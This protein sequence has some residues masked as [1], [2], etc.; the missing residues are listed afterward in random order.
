MLKNISVLQKPNFSLPKSIVWSE[1]SNAADSSSIAKTTSFINK[2]I[3]PYSRQGTLGGVMFTVKAD[4][5]E[6]ITKKNF[7]Q[8]RICLNRLSPI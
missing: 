5:I 7:L 6:G 1:V 4:C 8:V 2:N 3:I